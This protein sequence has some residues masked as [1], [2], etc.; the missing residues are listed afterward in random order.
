MREVGVRT[1]DGPG[2]A[3]G[4]VSERREVVEQERGRRRDRRHHRPERPHAM[5]DQE[6]DEDCNRQRRVGGAV[7]REEAAS[8]AGGG[9][10]RGG[11]ASR[12]CE[13]GADGQQL[14][15]PVQPE[16]LARDHPGSRRE[17][18]GHRRQEGPG[19]LGRPSRQE[20]EEADRQRRQQRRRELL[21]AQRG[22]LQ[23]PRLPAAPGQVSRRRG[24][25]RRDQDRR[26]D[27]VGPVEVARRRAVEPVGLVV[28]LAGRH[29]GGQPGH[30]IQVDA[31]RPP[32]GKRQ[33]ARRH[34]VAVL[35]DAKVEVVDD[36]RGQH[37]QDR[38]APVGARHG[39]ASERRSCTA[40][41]AAP[42]SAAE[43]GTTPRSA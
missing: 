1:A 40:V 3:A 15:H 30:R 33:Q 36:Q 28:R 23:A 12:R 26:D 35:D 42:V 21:H 43:L 10:A 38:R 39:A 27:R 29:R 37:E 20:I 13:E 31:P 5:A 18:V 41:P 19:R 2:V 17:A 14:S 22:V 34:R 4:P 24:I 8:Q 6:V 9:E 11:H 7:H 16:G 32:Q 25:E